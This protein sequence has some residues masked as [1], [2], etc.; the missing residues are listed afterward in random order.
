MIVLVLA[1]VFGGA[2]TA[3][4]AVSGIG[5]VTA[6]A[7]APLGGSLAA[8]AAAVLLASR[9]AG[10]ADEAE[11]VLLFSADEQVSALRRL[12]ELGRA[13][14]AKEKFSRRAACCSALTRLLVARGRGLVHLRRHDEPD[15]TGRCELEIDRDRIGSVGEMQEGQKAQ[16]RDR[17]ESRDAFGHRVHQRIHQLVAQPL[18]DKGTIAGFLHGAPDA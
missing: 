18:R 13:G 2:L 14:T 9:R 12:A 11:P 10:V 4:A 8:L 6:L 17:R 1:A 3:A 7:I 5:L 15:L 16:P